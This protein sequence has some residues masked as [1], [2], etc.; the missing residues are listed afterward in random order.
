M[1]DTF[2]IFIQ[3]SLEPVVNQTEF[4]SLPHVHTPIPF[5]LENI[6]AKLAVIIYIFITH[7]KQ[8]QGRVQI[9]YLETN[10]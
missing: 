4:S 5:T 9:I 6:K 10:F 3:P 2:H 8:E 7:I 1:F